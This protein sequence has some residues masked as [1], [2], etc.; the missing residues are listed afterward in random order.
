MLVGLAVAQLAIAVP[1]LLGGGTHAAHELGSWDIALAVGFLFAAWR[2]ERAAGM[3]PLV[4]AL[5]VLLLAT[6]GM[7][8]ADGDARAAREL[9]HVL[10][11][12]GL[13]CLWM[14][15]RRDQAVHWDRM[16]A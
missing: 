5:V 1:D 9:S 13:V 15:G 11:I 7:D 4:G 16:T 12:W 10:E 3:V 8:V 2:P 14:L 6:S